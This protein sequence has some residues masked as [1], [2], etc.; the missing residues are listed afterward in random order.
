MTPYRFS[1]FSDQ[2]KFL[3]IDLFETFTHKNTFKCKVSEN[4]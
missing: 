2:I 1:V 3:F 4:V